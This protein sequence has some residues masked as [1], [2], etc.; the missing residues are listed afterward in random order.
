[1][2]EEEVR[3]VGHGD[4]AKY[5]PQTIPTYFPRPL[6]PHGSARTN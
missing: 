3:G 5:D 2:S 1:M 4:L 6:T